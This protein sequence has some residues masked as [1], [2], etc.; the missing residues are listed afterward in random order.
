MSRL[1]PPSSANPTWRWRRQSSLMI[2][3]VASTLAFLGAV[4]M[5]AGQTPAPASVDAAFANFFRARTPQEVG[6][7][8]ERIVASGVGFEETFRRLRVGRVYSPDA[9]RGVVQASYRSENGEY[10]YTLDVPN[11][12]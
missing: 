8:S 5:S 1:M 6:A 9:P 12:Y 10:F 3:S 4:A 7:A 2:R 11:S